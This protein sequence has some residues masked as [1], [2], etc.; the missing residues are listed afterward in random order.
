MPVTLR[1]HPTATTREI[2]L[3]VQG[4]TCAACA[5]RVQ[6]KLGK[7]AGVTAAV[8][9]ATGT[10]RV[11]APARLPLEA[12]TDAVA[13]AGYSARPV[14]DVDADTDA[15]RHAS[16]LWHRLIVALVFFVPLTDLSLTLS[17]IPS[18]RFP[19]WPFVLIAC[20]APVAL[21]S[22]WPFHRAALVNLR[23][24]TLTMDTLVSLGVVAACGWSVW[25]MFALDRGTGGQSGLHQ[26]TRGSGGGIYLEV[27]AT[28]T[29]FLLAGRLYE[30]RA[31]RSAGAAM[32]ELAT[33]GAR[34][35]CL[36]DP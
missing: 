4:M 32:R 22:A 8:N 35:V 24:G 30:A 36:L 15:A 19:G 14:A 18:V 6:K 34:D 29:T 23:H 16:Y 31:R 21:W 28:V 1:T 26:L 2:D 11:T 10:A 7:L 33:S 9:Y 12:L 25:A 13:A 17:L 20:A 27:A 3:S 5:V